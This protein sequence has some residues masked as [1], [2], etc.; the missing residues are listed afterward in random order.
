M[1]SVE[2]CVVLF[3]DVFCYVVVCVLFCG[4]VCYVVVWCESENFIDP[5]GNCLIVLWCV[6]LLSDVV[7]SVLLWCVVLCS[8]M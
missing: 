6:K 7:C 2:W 4:L 3:C 1:R 8:D 5:G